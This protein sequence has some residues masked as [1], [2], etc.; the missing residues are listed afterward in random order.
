VKSETYLGLTDHV[1]IP[2]YGRKPCPVEGCVLGRIGEEVCDTCHGRGKEVVKC[3][4]CAGTMTCHFM[5]CLSGTVQY[6]VCN[7]MKVA[8][9][10][11]T[12]LLDSI[13]VLPADI[14]ER[15]LAL[16][17]LAEGA[18]WMDQAFAEY[19]AWVRGDRGGNLEELGPSNS[20]LFRQGQGTAMTERKEKEVK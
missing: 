15:N 10:S 4:H 6:D 5:D 11:M 3:D 13:R 20:A 12:N 2:G 9:S 14:T 17:R 16:A 19:F 1:H 8:K 7:A 18:M